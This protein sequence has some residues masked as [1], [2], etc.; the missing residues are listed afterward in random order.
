MEKITLTIDGKEVTGTAGQTIMEVARENGFHI[1]HLCYHPKLSKT[2]ACRLCIVRINNTMLKAS[3]TEPVTSGMSI[4]TEDD[5]IKSIRKWL[6][7]LILMEGD[8]NCLYCDADGDCNLQTY[9]KAYE[10][11]KSKEDFP[12]IEREIDYVT[13]NAIKRNENRCILCSRCV[14]TCKEIQVSN[15]WGFC[16]RGSATHL[17]ADDDKKIGESTCVKCGACVQYCPTGALTFQPVLGK[18][19]NW[20]L[21]KE[22]SICI[23]CGVGCKIDFY[24]NKE[25]LL[26]KTMGHDDG[27]NNGHLCVKGRFGFDFVQSPKRLTKPLIKKEGQFQEAGWDEALDY[28]AQ[29]L[30][31]TK[32]QYGPDAIAGLSSAK[33]TNEENYVMQKFMRSVIG[34]NNIDHC[35]RL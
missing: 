30:T 3:C 26:V 12:S 21:Q 8:H 34:T 15:V 22:S 10:V 4:I 33:C 14:R 6:L 7:G 35:A 27:P 1:P 17:I 2:G 19:P 20:E 16:E 13:S 5:G 18:G 24:T 11:E 32:E 29:K 9:V 23:Y 25:G 28:V 31:T